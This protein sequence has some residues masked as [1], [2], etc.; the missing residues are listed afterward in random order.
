[1]VGLAMLAMLMGWFVVNAVVNWWQVVQDDM[2][3]GRPRTYQV[4]QVVGHN[5]SQLHPSHFIAL[6]L[7]RHVE[8]IEF[9]G[10][11]VSLAR[12]Y[13]GPVLLGQGQDLA[14]VTLTFKDVNHD[15]KPDMILNVQDSH[16]IFIN[17]NGQFRTARPD[18][19]ISHS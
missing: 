13:V 5:D 10:G 16:I 18:D 4:D 1:M 19:N 12:V 7:N 8:V 17:D 2:H 14:V 3:Y 11:D 9:P 15:Q 6:N